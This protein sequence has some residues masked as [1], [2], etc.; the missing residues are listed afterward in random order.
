MINLNLYIGKV[1]STDDP[2]QKGKIQI[3]LLPEFKDVPDEDCIWIPSFF[4]QQINNVAIN[5]IVWVLSSA[6][7]QSNE[8]Y[9]IPKYFVDGLIDFTDI[10]NILTNVTDKGTNNYKDMRFTLYPDGSLIYFNISTGEK[11]I[12]QSDGSY[13]LIDT[14]GNIYVKPH[15]KFKLYNTVSLKDILKDLQ[16][17][18][19]D[20]VTPLNILDSHGAPCTFTTVGTDLPKIQS[21][22]TNLNLLLKD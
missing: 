4:N 8:M 9:Y 11:A 19:L 1:I 15:G 12:V 20:L 14:S 16:A 6:Y 2:D 22:L 17:V 5:D 13:I 10:T 18:L 21:V 7:F 3:K